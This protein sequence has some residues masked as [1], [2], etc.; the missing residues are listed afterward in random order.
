MDLN[1]TDSAAVKLVAVERAIDVIPQGPWHESTAHGS[2]YNQN[3]K[4]DA[5][6]APNVVALFT[7]QGCL[8]GSRV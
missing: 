1:G 6:R 7:R 2:D 5:E 8:F 3:D 4:D